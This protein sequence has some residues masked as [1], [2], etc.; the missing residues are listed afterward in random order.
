MH[1][2]VGECVCMGVSVVLWL[3]VC[4][5]GRVCV[6]VRSSVLHECVFVC[7]YKHFFDERKMLSTCWRREMY[8]VSSVNEYVW[9]FFSA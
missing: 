2:N 4:V 9:G 1:V 8:G 6:M 7:A 5:C 3:V